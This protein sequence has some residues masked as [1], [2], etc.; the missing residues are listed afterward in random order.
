MQVV[1]IGGGALMVSTGVRASRWGDANDTLVLAPV[2]VR[3]AEL[4]V[5]D[6]GAVH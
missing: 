3:D 4:P 6:A 5:S 2:P 1:Q